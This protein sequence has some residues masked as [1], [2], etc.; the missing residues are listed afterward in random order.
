M[1][2]SALGG[3]CIDFYGLQTRFYDGILYNNIGISEGCPAILAAER[4]KG[5][6]WILKASAIYD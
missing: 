4:A 6:C 2:R 5:E 1:Q 3:T